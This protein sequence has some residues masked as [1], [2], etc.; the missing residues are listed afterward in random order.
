MIQARI[1]LPDGIGDDVMERVKQ[2]AADKHGGYT[3]YQGRGGWVNDR[4]DLVEETTHVLEVSGAGRG[5]AKAT[6]NHVARETGE[7]AVMW[8]TRQIANGGLERGSVSPP[9]GD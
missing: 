9:N 3:I 4:G 5:W 2:M 7:D 1:Y 6:A 8:E